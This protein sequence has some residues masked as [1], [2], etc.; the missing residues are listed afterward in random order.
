MCI[1]PILIWLAPIEAGRNHF[2]NKSLVLERGGSVGGVGGVVQLRSPT[3]RFF[4]R[5]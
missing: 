2:P 1:L 3:G 4:P 5:Q